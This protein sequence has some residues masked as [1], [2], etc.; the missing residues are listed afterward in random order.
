MG[1]PQGQYRHR[2]GGCAAL[3]HALHKLVSGGQLSISIGA[4][5]LGRPSWLDLGAAYRRA[6]EALCETKAGGRDQAALR[7][8][9][10][11]AQAAVWEDAE[12]P[13]LSTKTRSGRTRKPGGPGG[14]FCPFAPRAATQPRMVGLSRQS[15]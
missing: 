15:V 9:P 2:R 3:D 10:P 5:V 13:S 6:Q 4:T 1:R 12:S 7:M 8:P 11:G 14:N